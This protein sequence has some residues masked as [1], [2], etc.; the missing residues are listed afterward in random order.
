MKKKKKEVIDFIFF[1]P[2]I[3]L[4]QQPVPHYTK[5]DRKHQGV[6]TCININKHIII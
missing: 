1:E 3:Y 6:Q 4:F 5:D 2:K